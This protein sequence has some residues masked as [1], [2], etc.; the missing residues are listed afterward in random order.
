[1]TTFDHFTVSVRKVSALTR[2]R[3]A[4]TV[5]VCVTS[6]APDAVNGKTRISWEPW[7][8]SVRG[9]SPR[10]PA[11]DLTG[12][13]GV[14]PPSAYYQSGDCGQ[15]IIPFRVP[16]DR[17]PTAVLYRNGQGDVANFPIDP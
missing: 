16:E 13:P 12:L 11:E 5:R 3:F 9:M 6:P 17:Q 7:L 10:T 1:M 2:D 8:L 4:V 15:G 14:L